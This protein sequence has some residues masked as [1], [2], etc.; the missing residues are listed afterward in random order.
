MEAKREKVT[1]RG[2]VGVTGRRERGEKEIRTELNNARGRR[3]IR[4]RWE[5]G[6]HGKRRELTQ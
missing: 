3:G 2:V 4:K 1:G 6:K 5:G